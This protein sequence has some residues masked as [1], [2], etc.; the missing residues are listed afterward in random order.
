MKMKVKELIK[1]L[2]NCNENAEVVIDDTYNI[3]FVWDCP[4]VNKVNI[5]TEPTKEMFDDME[6]ENFFL[7]LAEEV[8]QGMGEMLDSMKINGVQ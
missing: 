8:E 6:K 3:G 4:T 7:N 1:L 5:T 2:Q